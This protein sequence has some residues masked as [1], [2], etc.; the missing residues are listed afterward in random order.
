MAKPKLAYIRHITT[1]G[2][3]LVFHRREYERFWG[4]QNWFLNRQEQLDKNKKGAPVKEVPFLLTI[5]F[6]FTQV[7]G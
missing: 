5:H 1:V 7:E 2:L 6:C 3:P 4:K